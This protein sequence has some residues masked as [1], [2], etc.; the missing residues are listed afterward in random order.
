MPRSVT[1]ANR[2]PAAARARPAFGART[3][4]ERMRGFTLIEILVV[5]VIASVMA[6]FAV[7]A[8]DRAGPGP[9]NERTLARIEAAMNLMCDQALLSGSVHGLRF[10]RAGYD[11]WVLR[12]EGWIERPSETAVT[13][14]WP[15]GETPRIRI[16]SLRWEEQRDSGPQVLCTGIEPPTPVTIELGEGDDR[17]SLSWP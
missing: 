17:R 12:P 11:F 7:L 2:P 15:D 3:L 13:G 5:V 1:G 8:F 10:S 4:R 9:T 14:R 16:A 6:G